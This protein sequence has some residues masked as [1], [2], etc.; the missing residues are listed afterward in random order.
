[1]AANVE[2]IWAAL[3]ERLSSRTEDRFVTVS[4]SLAIR[5]AV[6]QYPILEIVEGSEEPT[7]DGDLS[8]LW[9]LTGV[10]AIRCRVKDDNPLWTQLNDL[11]RSVREALERL[12]TDRETGEYHGQHQ[13]WTNLDGLVHSLSLGRV[14][15]AVG[16]TGEGWARIDL[17]MQV[18]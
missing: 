6:D 10:L 16:D 13:H 3:H 14:E 9:T 8:P 7:Q 11:V 17:E 5:G 1:M 4:R 18:F 2:A 12:P 15:K